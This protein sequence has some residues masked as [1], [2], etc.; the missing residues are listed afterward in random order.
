MSKSALNIFNISIYNQLIH[1]FNSSLVS[2]EKYNSIYE[3]MQGYYTKDEIHYI[4]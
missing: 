4:V 3:K 1:N 2:L